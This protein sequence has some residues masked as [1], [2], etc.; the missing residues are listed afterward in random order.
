M[1]A[2]KWFHKLNR[3]IKGSLRFRLF[4]LIF[5][6]IFPGTLLLIHSI[7][8]QQHREVLA[9]YII[10]ICSIHTI[11]LGGDI[12]ILRSVSSLIELSKRL[13]SGDLT[14]R[15]RQT[16]SSGL[17]GELAQSLNRIATSLKEETE[18][19][20]WRNDMGEAFIEIVNEFAGQHD[21]TTLLQ[22]IVDKVMT[23]LNT[24][25]VAISLYDASRSELEF[26]A[27]SGAQVPVGT[28]IRMRE[29]TVVGCVSENRQPLIVD[30][31][32]LWEGRLPEFE[33]L[34]IHNCS[35]STDSVSGRTDWHIGSSGNRLV[36]EV[37]PV[38]DP[39]DEVKCGGGSERNKKTRACSKKHIAASR[40]WRQSARSPRRYV[41]PKRSMQCCPCSSKKR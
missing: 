40:S 11:W 19:L 25:Y 35:A 29:G 17:F 14:A 18:K 23:L 30:Q 16:N 8:T 7:I 4:L 41:L 15:P 36:A 3:M 27:V 31:Y 22:L 24:S 38:G 32:D 20:Q 37:R 1:L 26:V 6:S 9:V 10:V 33:S 2:R 12:L 28:R 21:I 5:L 34:C 39:S 13:S